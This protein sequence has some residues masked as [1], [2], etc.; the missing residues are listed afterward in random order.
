MGDDG[1]YLFVVESGKLECRKEID[2]V[3]TQVKVSGLR[4]EW[5]PGCR[6]NNPLYILV[7]QPA[8]EWRV[9]LLHWEDMEEIVWHKILSLLLL[10]PF[11][12]RT[13]LVRCHKSVIRTPLRRTTTS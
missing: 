8:S 5:V 3:D 7:L 2:G 12:K 1:D 10:S 6:A 4:G 13:V 9:C 11:M